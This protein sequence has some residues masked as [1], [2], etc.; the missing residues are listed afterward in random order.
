MIYFISNDDNL[1]VLGPRSNYVSGP[2]L[3]TDIQYNNESSLEAFAVRWSKLQQEPITYFHRIVFF[4]TLFKTQVLQEI[5]LLDERFEL[6]NFDDDDYCRRVKGRGFSLAIANN[7]FIHHYGSRTF[8][9]NNID[10]ARAMEIN[11]KKF[12]QKWGIKE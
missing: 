9:L 1:M 10:Y 2:Q 12:M 7:V 11:K 8:A 6:G 4:C 5:G 3:V